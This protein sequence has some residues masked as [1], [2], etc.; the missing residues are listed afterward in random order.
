MPKADRGFFLGA[1][2]GATKAT[3]VIIDSKGE[4]VSLAEGPGT[5]HETLESKEFWAG[6][7]KVISQALHGCRGKIKY[8]CF[9][10]A[11]IDTAN[12]MRAAKHWMSKSG[13]EA[14]LK[15]PIDIF[16]DIQIVLPAIG[17]TEGV[18]AIAGTGSAFYGVRNGKNAKAGGLDCVLTDEGSA[19]D[20]GVTALRAAVRSWDGR[21]HKTMLERMVFA[22]TGASNGFELK[23]KMHGSS[24]SVIASFAKLVSEAE[25]KGDNVAKKILDSAGTECVMGINAVI[26]RLNFSGSFDIALTGKL[27][28]KGVLNERVRANL[29]QNHP[30]VKIRIVKE[31]AI[32]AAKLAMDLSKQNKARKKP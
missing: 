5:T 26:K 11:G 29:D 22:K 10:M 31:P 20:I 12:D 7:V 8:A 27:F 32:G 2:C 24:K 1:D 21:G 13:M 14:L 30:Q 28:S 3:V 9:G 17:V 25:A 23:D 16:N 4:I 19:Y 15:C 6:M 18:V